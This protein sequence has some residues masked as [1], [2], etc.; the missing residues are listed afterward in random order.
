MVMKQCTQLLKAHVFV[1]YFML[2]T[3]PLVYAAMLRDS[4]PE[5]RQ[6]PLMSIYTHIPISIGGAFSKFPAASQNIPQGISDNQSSVSGFVF[7]LGS[8]FPFWATIPW[9]KDVRFGLQAETQ[10]LDGFFT[11]SST[12]SG[13]AGGSQ[14]LYEAFFSMNSIAVM[15][16]LRYTLASGIS[17]QAGLNLSMIARSALRVTDSTLGVGKQETRNG[18]LQAVR[19]LQTGL[20][21]VVS[22]PLALAPNNAVSLR[23]ELSFNIPFLPI[24][25]D[26]TSWGDMI[27]RVRFGVSLVFDTHPRNQQPIPIDTVFRRDTTLQ[28]LTSVREPRV[29]LVSR[30]IRQPQTTKVKD[31]EENLFGVIGR[32][33]TG[34]PPQAPPPSKPFA[35]N[36]VTNAVIIQESYRREVPKPKPLIT[37][38]VHAEFIM[39]D[40]KRER[41]V[42]VKAE[43]TIVRLW[44]SPPTMP[45]VGFLSNDSVALKPYI[46]TD[47]LLTSRLPTVRFFPRI[48]SEVDIQG[49]TLEVTQRGEVLARFFGV[50]IADTS[51]TWTPAEEPEHVIR[52][53]ERLAYKL[54]VVDDEQKAT[55]ADSGFINVEQEKIVGSNPVKRTID[56]VFLEDETGSSFDQQPL[57]ERNRTLLGVVSRSIQASSRLR[58]IT[59]CPP[60]R[61]QQ[62]RANEVANVLHMKPER[63]INAGGNIVRASNHRTMLVIETE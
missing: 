9:L 19:S 59:F 5:T 18:S 21:F 16:T 23:P 22:Y 54:I 49:W 34:V 29:M 6:S 42:K 7:G 10:F 44:S 11:A 17:L 31:E 57:N 20:T 33:V 13:T 26:G 14:K 48:I 53:Q 58:L 40:G 28:M 56:L 37:A 12:M 55:I 36:T 8:E 43:K 51:V 4:L 27:P 46:I 60:S 25:T 2:F 52:A 32:V 62:E 41:T 3:S 47:T 63:L 50:S 39:P 15:P 61:L 1:L 24:S 38:N 35:T 45:Q 30:V